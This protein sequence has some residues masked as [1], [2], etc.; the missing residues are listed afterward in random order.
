M[1]SAPKD[2]PVNPVNL[3]PPTG[4]ELKST[5]ADTPVNPE[6][7]FTGFTGVGGGAYLEFQVL[8]EGCSS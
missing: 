2:T 7:R 3:S 5:P 8:L 1:K 6:N 4:H